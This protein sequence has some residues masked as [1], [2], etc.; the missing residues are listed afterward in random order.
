M[1]EIFTLHLKYLE[2][3]SLSEWGPLIHDLREMLNEFVHLIPKDRSKITLEQLH[4]AANRSNEILIGMRAR[5]ESH[6]H[7][8]S[9][10]NPI[11][12]ILG[13]WISTETSSLSTPEELKLSRDQL[14]EIHKI[15]FPR[16]AKD[17]WS[18]F[19]VP[20]VPL[21]QKR[22]RGRPRKRPVER[23]DEQPM[24]KPRTE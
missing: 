19:D 8:R 15:L 22:P 7:F 3:E 6:D 10:V 2:L 17:H 1:V 20:M 21:I 24:K 11:C 5:D 9:F 14:I 4:S 12:S 23:S 16:L 18:L 13:R